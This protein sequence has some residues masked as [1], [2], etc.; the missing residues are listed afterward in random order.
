L[1]FAI[2][3]L[4]LEKS[5]Q[6]RIHL[7]Q[8]ET[9]SIGIDSDVFMVTFDFGWKLSEYIVFQHTCNHSGKKFGGFLKI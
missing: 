9:V 5:W 8:L 1:S 2:S 4:K 3:S 7:G 6:I